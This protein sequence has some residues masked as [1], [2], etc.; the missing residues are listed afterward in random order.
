MMPISQSYCVI[1]YDSIRYSLS[2]FKRIVQ[3]N[4]DDADI[5]NYC[6]FLQTSNCI[7][8]NHRAINTGVLQKMNHD[9]EFFRAKNKDELETFKSQ[10]RKNRYSEL[11][12]F[13]PVD[14]PIVQNFKFVSIKADAYL[15]QFTTLTDVSREYVNEFEANRKIHEILNC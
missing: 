12:W 11:L 9:S 7:F 1:L 10:P 2:D 5:L 14:L 4:N 6:Q 15:D 3:I 13:H 8:F